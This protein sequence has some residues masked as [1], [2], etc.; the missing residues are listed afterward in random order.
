[1]SI[2]VARASPAFCPVSLI[3]TCK[4]PLQ[5]CSPKIWHGI[6]SLEKF[7]L[8][9]LND[10]HIS[11]RSLSEPPSFDDT[12]GAVIIRDMDGGIVDPKY[13]VHAPP[14]PTGEGNCTTRVQAYFSDANATLETETMES[15]GIL[16][17]IHPSAEGHAY[18]QWDHADMPTPS[19]PGAMCAWHPGLNLYREVGA[20]PPDV[21][22]FTLSNVMDENQTHVQIHSVNGSFPDTTATVHEV[23][24]GT[25]GKIA[26][27]ATLFDG[28]IYRGIMRANSAGGEA[29]CEQKVNRTTGEMY[30]ADCPVVSW[31]AAD[32][33]SS[34]WAPVNVPSAYSASCTE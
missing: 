19:P 31:W 13:C 10:T 3:T 30:L 28:K 4:N 17:W 32:G 34:C 7:E 18:G 9:P 1:M 24:A 27:R 5:K 2:T 29:C 6:D 26:W 12:T 25:P 33:S 16:T 21:R 23:G 20:N 14:A 11:I 8:A 15:C 22:Y